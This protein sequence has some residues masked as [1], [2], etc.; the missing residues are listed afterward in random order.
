MDPGVPL[1]ILPRIRDDFRV[2]SVVERKTEK[3]LK[4]GIRYRER[5]MRNL[6]NKRINI[7]LYIYIYVY[8]MSIYI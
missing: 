5:A 3:R 8:M 6:T 4:P 1:G 2:A 7:Y